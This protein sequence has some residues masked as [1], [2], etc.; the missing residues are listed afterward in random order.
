[1]INHRFFYPP[2]AVDVRRLPTRES[3]KT[4]EINGLWLYGV[5]RTFLAA[6]VPPSSSTLV[7]TGLVAR[8]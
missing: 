5:W 4:N 2:S 1:M 7:T 8:F 6:G 3:R